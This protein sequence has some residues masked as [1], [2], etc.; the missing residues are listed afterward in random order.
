MSIE[1]LRPTVQPSGL[2]TPSYQQ[3]SSF[4]GEP[5]KG[6]GSGGVDF[7]GSANLGLQN[8]QV[9]F[10]GQPQQAI[11]SK[12]LASSQPVQ[13]D[14]LMTLVRDLVQQISQL[15]SQ[16]MQQNQNS[17]LDPS[18]S[19]S[20]SGKASSKPEQQRVANG[21][22]PLGSPVVGGS[23]DTPPASPTGST[24]PDASPPIQNKA[25]NSLSSKDGATPAGGFGGTAG[26]GDYTVHEVNNLD[27]AVTMGEFDK[28]EKLIAE[29]HLA[30]KG[31][32][33]SEGDMKYEKDT[34]ILIKD[35]AN[36]DANGNGGEYRSDASRTEAYNGF[37]NISDIDGRSVSLRG[38]DETGFEIGDNK[39]IAADAVKAGLIKNEDE[40]IPGWYDGSTAEMQKGGAFL[41]QKLGTGGAYI[42][43]NDDQLGEGKNPM[44]HTDSMT[45]NLEIG[46]A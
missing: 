1:A 40:T 11:N 22:A 46:K 38:T 18:N 31:Q 34:T 13:D 25:S 28:N 45:L 6:Q 27:H 20:G 26:H 5:S 17:G 14:N 30:A 15:L 10:S 3:P 37:K 24:L 16:F 21:D 12:A 42:H 36:T 44:R 35:K 23:P 41:E 7:G 4:Q 33:G 9:N 29:L 2:D 32:P 39:S 43:P 19:E 8:N